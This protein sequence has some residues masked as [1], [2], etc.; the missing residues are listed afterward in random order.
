MTKTTITAFILCISCLFFLG[1]F[2]H[3]KKTQRIDNHANQSLLADNKALDL[4]NER[5]VRR[6]INQATPNTETSEEHREI[7]ESYLF[8]LNRSNQLK[9]AFEKLDG[10]ESA[11]ERSKIYDDIRVMI[12]RTKEDKEI[13]NLEAMNIEV[14]L[15]SNYYDEREYTSAKKEILQRYKKTSDEE[16][17]RYLN[18][19]DP[20][21]I[22]FQKK[23][24]ELLRKT[25]N[26]ESFPNDLSKDEYIKSQI[27][28][29]KLEVYRE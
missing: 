28:K 21:V 29:L 23:Q 3:D 18:N 12:E 16:W 25:N 19:R 17:T 27:E 1:I 11:D 14:L 22:E 13:T 20:K 6:T 2:L 8:K 24:I 26:M 15:A 10:I 7:L 4:E 5:S 9:V